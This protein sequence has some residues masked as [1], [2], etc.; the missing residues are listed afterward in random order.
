METRQNPLY[1]RIDRTVNLQPMDYNESALF[2]ESFRL[3]DRVRLYSV[4]GGIPRYNR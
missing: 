2:Y 3:E 4:F 1:G